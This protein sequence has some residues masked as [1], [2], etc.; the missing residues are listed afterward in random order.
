MVYQPNFGDYGAAVFLPILA[1]IGQ[2]IFRKLIPTAGWA[3]RTTDISRFK[4]AALIS[5]SLIALSLCV[6]RRLNGI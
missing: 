1:K 4:T 5:S 3:A 6:D 2:K